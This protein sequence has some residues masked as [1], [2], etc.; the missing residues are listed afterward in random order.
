MSDL[1]PERAAFDARLQALRLDWLDPREIERL[2]QSRKAQIRIGERL[3]AEAD[4]A[5]E[6][7][8]LLDMSLR[9]RP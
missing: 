4:P 8:L 7:A 6:S 9:G 5:D 3:R 2:W 1:T